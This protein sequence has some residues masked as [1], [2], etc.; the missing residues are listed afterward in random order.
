[1][2]KRMVSLLVCVVIIVLSVSGCRAAQ[3]NSLSIA[4]S[5]TPGMT[6][7]EVFDMLGEPYADLGSGIVYD[8]YILSDEYVATVAYE[9]DYVDDDRVWCVCGADIHTYERF[10]ELWGNYPDDPTA[11]WNKYK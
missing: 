11:W 6:R 5:I 1:M 8:L 3:A 7:G 4:Q 9:V 2:A 10:K